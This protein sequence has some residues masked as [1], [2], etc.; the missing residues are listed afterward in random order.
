M[1]SPMKVVRLVPSGSPGHPSDVIA[2]PKR[3][4]SQS[5]GL[6]NAN[7]PWAPTG[8]PTDSCRGPAYQG[9]V[10]LSDSWTVPLPHPRW[11]PPTVRSP[12]IVEFRPGHI[13][14]QRA[15]NHPGSGRGSIPKRCNPGSESCHHRRTGR[16]RN[17]IPPDTFPLLMNRPSI[18]NRF[19]RSQNPVNR[20]SRRPD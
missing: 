10:R 2:S 20:R 17:C 4:V 11:S 5:T 9:C 7:W 1:R 18:P 6:H 14:F 8:R 15:S 19:S 12:L 16:Y 3:G 13:S